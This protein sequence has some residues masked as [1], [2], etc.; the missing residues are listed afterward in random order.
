MRICINRNTLYE[1]GNDPCH[2]TTLWFL[3][4]IVVLGT[5]DIDWGTEEFHSWALVADTKIL[6]RQYTNRTFWFFTIQLFGFG[7]GLSNQE[8]Y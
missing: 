2:Q 1:S 3:T 8:G 7:F 6:F 4:P 5:R